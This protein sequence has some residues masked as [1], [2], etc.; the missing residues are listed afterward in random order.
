MFTFQSA[1]IDDFDRLLQ[2]RLRT[3]RESLE[4]IG[5]FDEWRAYDRFRNSYRPHYTRLIINPEGT[6][7]GCVAMGPVD[8]HLL[9]EHFYIFPELQAQGLGSRVLSKLL[10]EADR[11][12]LPVRLSVL[13]QSDAGRFYARHGFIETGED[14]WDVFYE[15]QPQT[16]T[17]GVAGEN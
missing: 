16:A 10:E 15:R 2:L 17:Q 1:S 3:M 9:L 4:R 11:A 12:G 8:D 7:A 14:E 6:L 5:R 13:Q